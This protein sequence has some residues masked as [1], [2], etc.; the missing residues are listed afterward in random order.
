[1]TFS[2]WSGTPEDVAAARSSIESEIA[3]STLLTVY[4]ETM[5]KTPDVAAHKWLADGE[6][7]SLTYRQV[8]ERVRDAA[9]GLAAA[10]A[11]G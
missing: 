2:D 9:L 7:R 11:A 1:M 10:A 3:G 8:H 5:A 6:W 4:A